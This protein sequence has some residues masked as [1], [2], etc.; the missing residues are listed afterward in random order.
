LIRACRKQR[1]ELT[2]RKLLIGERLLGYGNGHARETIRALEAEL[3][4]LQDLMAK[5]WR[6]HSEICDMP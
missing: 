1:T 6:I 5:L 3:A 4:L 2:E